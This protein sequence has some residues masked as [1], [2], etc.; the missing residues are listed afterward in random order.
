M[1]DG[2]RILTTHVGS[3]P[4]PQDVVDAVFSVD[5]GEAVD[6]EQ[7]DRVIREAVRDRV[8]HQ[9]EA[10]ID[11]VSDGEMSKIGYATYH[12][13]PPQRLRGRR[14]AKGHASRPGRLS[15]VP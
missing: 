10:G 15:A 2:K 7:H 1:S 8:G 14:R 11:V 13:P 3:L 12:P 5:R 9:V 6:R 4:R